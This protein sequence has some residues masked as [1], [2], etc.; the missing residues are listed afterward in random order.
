M[1][2]P[3]LPNPK[4][5]VKA[6]RQMTLTAWR[7][8]CLNELC[9]RVVLLDEL[10]EAIRDDLVSMLD[11]CASIKVE[12]MDDGDDRMGLHMIPFWRKLEHGELLELKD[13]KAECQSIDYLTGDWIKNMRY[14]TPDHIIGW[15][16][17]MK[18]LCIG[19]IY[20]KDDPDGLTGAVQGE[21]Y[22]DYETVAA[23]Q[24]WVSLEPDQEWLAIRQEWS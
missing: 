3:L 6:V 18:R 5:V 11:Q 7:N 12:V 21:S 16:C 19:S 4:T 14:P 13:Q 8:W 20:G 17:I 9:R 22:V 24:W 10:P 15:D 23:G 2:N 1:F